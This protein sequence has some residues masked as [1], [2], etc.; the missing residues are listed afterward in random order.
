M[1]SNRKKALP[2]GIS[3]FKEIIENNYYFIDKSLLIKELLETKAKVTLFPR[4]RR[5]GKT[6]NMNMLQYFFEKTERSNSHL[7]KNLA[8][9]QYPKIMEHQGQYPAIFLTFKDIKTNTWDGCYQHLKSVISLEY[10][11]LEYLLE[12]PSLGQHEKKIF[13]AIIDKNADQVEYEIS[14]L[15]LSRYLHAYHKKPAIILID[16]YDMP[17]VAG[18]TFGYYED[19]VGFLRNF[20]SGGLKDNSNLAY[21]VM[22]GIVRIAKESIFSG[23]NNLD[24]CSMA[25]DHYADKFGLLE[26][27]VRDLLAYYELSASIDDVRTWYN[28]YSSGQ[29]KVY[30]PWSIIN[31]ARNN[32]KLEPYWINT[33]SND[34]IKQLLQ[35]GSLQLKKDLELILQRKQVTKAFDHGL[36]FPELTKQDDAVWNLLFY[37]GYLTVE[38]QRLNEDDEIVVDFIVPNNEVLAFFKTSIRHWFVGA[39]RISEQYK[40]MLDSLTSGNVIF[41]ATVFQQMVLTSLSS[42]DVGGNEPERF[43]HALV[44]GMLLSLQDRYEVTS[45]R[46]SGYGRYDV[47]IIPRDI[48]KLGIILEFKKAGADR[49]ETL[50]E[51]AENALKQIIDKQYDVELGSR[52]IQNILKLGIAFKGKQVCIKHESAEGIK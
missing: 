25:S 23:L 36:V 9:N 12:A 16:E 13:Q 18:Y 2:I 38:N 6:L 31:C 3:D 26:H 34:L 27:E 24:V 50:E 45:N 29:L 17:I 37:S 7:F 51:S 20:L 41:F 11:R 15:N 8:V 49:P 32:G 48:T 33:S 44:V 52:G 40:A 47:M 14:L 19:V 22:T 10:K 39:S 46:E 1:E 35:E 42:F 21:S 43:Y 5:F 4:P 28:G 30:N